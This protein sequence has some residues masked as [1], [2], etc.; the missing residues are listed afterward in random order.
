MTD[1]EILEKIKSM[2]NYTGNFH[3]D[4]LLGWI[5]EAKDKLYDSGVS[6]EAIER[7]CGGVIA[8][9]V[10]DETENGGLTEKTEKR[11]AQKALSFPRG[12]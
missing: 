4:F 2:S 5:E 6:K 12:D 3:D 9:I 8:L 10:I 11:I 1:L 7:N